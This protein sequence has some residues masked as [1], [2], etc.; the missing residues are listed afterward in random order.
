MP[1]PARISTLQC[2]TATRFGAASSACGCYPCSVLL[3]TDQLDQ[4][5][6]RLLMPLQRLAR[7]PGDMPQRLAWMGLIDAVVSGV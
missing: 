5:S 4:L 7:A 3:Q 6:T 1:G 2:A